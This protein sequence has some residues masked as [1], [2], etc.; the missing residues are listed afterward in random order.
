MFPG[1][2]RF[3]AIATEAAESAA[4]PLFEA[5]AIANPY[6]ARH[7]PPVPWAR[8]VL[9]AIFAGVSIERVDGLGGRV[10]PELRRLCAD[11]VAAEQKRGRKVPPDATRLATWPP[12]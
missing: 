10:T 2:E 4:V 12:A 6:P 7:F 9:R 5:I 3:L 1:P 11:H 8:L